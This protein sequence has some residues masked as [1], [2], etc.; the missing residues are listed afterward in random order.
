MIA[1]KGVAF[2]QGLYLRLSKRASVLSNWSMVQGELLQFIAAAPGNRMVFQ[3][4]H[5]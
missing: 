1:K 3:N 2:L 4:T 5:L